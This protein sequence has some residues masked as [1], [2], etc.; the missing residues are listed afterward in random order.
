MPG[1]SPVRASIVAAAS[2]YDHDRFGTLPADIVKSFSAFTLSFDS[3]DDGE[4]LG[5][6]EWVAYE[7]RATPP[8]LG[9]AP[10]RPSRW[11]TDQA[12]HQQRV[13]PD[14]DSYK[15]SG[16]SRGHMC[17][18]SHA[19]RISDLADIETHTVLNAC[20]QMQGMN[21]GI[22]KA[23]EDLTGEWADAH[24]AVWIVTGPV[25]LQAKQRKWIGDEGEVP[26]AIPD[27]FFKVVARE[28]GNSCEVLAFLVP[29][30]GD[31]GHS[32]SSGDVRPYLTNVDIIEAVTG[33]DFLTKLADPL[34]ES[35]EQR[36]FTELWATAPAVGP[37]GEIAAPRA[38]P[39]PAV[40][41]ATPAPRSTVAAP[42]QDPLSGVALRGGVQASAAEE[43]LAKQ[44]KN[45]GWE[46]VMPRPKSAQA[47]WGNNDG[48]TTWWR[49][50]WRNAVNKTF[51]STQPV[52]ANAWKG[53]GIQ[54][55]GWKRGGAPP[56]PTVVEWLCSTGGGV[57]PR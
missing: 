18:K 27:A 46:Y 53:D 55:V 2:G 44:I 26:V 8:A 28:Y 25:F 4:C 24:G 6:P 9:Q 11:A 49:G 38:P 30:E 51:S 10:A 45:A 35:I 7:L 3:N 17:M 41:P 32:K 36:I 52:Q 1:A 56:R 22:W 42:V 37:G 15:G 34:E 12:L 29:M 47:A 23:I 13:A 50:Y 5:V 31:A 54:N 16:Y 40:V 20:P 57:P 19:H 21:N 39:P 14:D 48:R 43:R 33:L